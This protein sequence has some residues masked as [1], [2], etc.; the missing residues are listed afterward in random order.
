ME[1]HN[2]GCDSVSFLKRSKAAAQ[3]Q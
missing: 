2:P 3:A 1:G